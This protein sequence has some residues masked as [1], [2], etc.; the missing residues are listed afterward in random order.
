MSDLE[1]EIRNMRARESRCR[2]CLGLVGPKSRDLQEQP[3]SVVFSD[4]EERTEVWR[5]HSK[6]CM[7]RYLKWERRYAERLASRNARRSGRSD[8]G[9]VILSAEG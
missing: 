6:L 1:M 4:G 8:P 2:Y 5:F 7:G 3:R 9:D